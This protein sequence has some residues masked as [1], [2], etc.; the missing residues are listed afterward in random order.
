MPSIFGGLDIAQQSLAAQQFALSI[1]QKNVSNANRP[2]YTR[3]DIVYTDD[4]A[5]WARSG[6]P[7]ISMQAVRDRYVDYS[8]CQETQAK[9]QYSIES[10]ALQR[11]DALFNGSGEGLQNALTN[12]FNSFSALSAAPEDL[13]LR[14]KVLSSANALTLEF[15]RL[16]GGL[17][18]IQTSQDRALSDAVSEANSLTAQIAELNRKVAVAQGEHSA[19]EFTLRDSRQELLEQLSGLIDLSYYETE[20]G[21]VTVTTRQGAT[22]VVG[23]QSNNLELSIAGP[24]SFQRVMLDDVDITSSLESGKISGLIDVR[25][26]KTA[27]YL[28]ALDDLAAAVISRVNQVHTGGSDL[29]G[30]RGGN[31]FNPFVQPVA[32][33]NAG[34]ASTM[35]VAITDPED[36]AAAEL[37]GE[38]GNNENAKILAGIVDE[39]LL[40]GGTESSGE[41]Y[42]GL[43][44]RIGADEK[45]ADDNS[46]TQESILSQLKNQRDAFSGVNLDAEAVNIIKYQKAYQASA[47]YANVLNGLSDEILQL[48]GA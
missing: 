44:Y 32:G 19:D 34:A 4:E 18:Q 1:T 28:G 12:F 27:G 2:G 9:A 42:K 24:G 20:S 36:I 16:Y 8:I 11:V 21:T 43:I 5:E 33:S 7:G 46:A 3:Q 10:D 31:F 30:A 37:N 41:F 47:R 35:T 25:D 15:H 23:D 14:Q 13:T 45:A 38:A 22:L 26:N 6:V 39:K 40:S 17:Q 48:L 29:G